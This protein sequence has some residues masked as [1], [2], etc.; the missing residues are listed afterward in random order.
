MNN[1]GIAQLIKSVKAPYPKF[2]ERLY[3]VLHDAE[4]SEKVNVDNPEKR[5]MVWNAYAE[6]IESDVAPRI[7]R[8]A[9]RP[10]FT[11]RDALTKAPED[12]YAAISTDEFEQ[13]AVQCDFSDSVEEVV[14]SL[15]TEY[16][17]SDESVI[18]QMRCSMLVV[19]SWSKKRP[20]ETKVYGGNLS[21]LLTQSLV[22]SWIK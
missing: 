18:E 13:Y 1:E 3:I 16:M 7:H 14:E 19:L 20:R 17:F 22:G 9:A 11:V 21:D 10:P 8:F 2:K 15:M 5:Q 12:T 4:L 6:S